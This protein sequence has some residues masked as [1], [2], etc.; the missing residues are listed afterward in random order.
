MVVGRQEHIYLTKK[1]NGVADV[2]HFVDELFWEQIVT[3]CR[4]FG[5]LMML[6]LN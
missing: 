6:T 2:F 5:S 3:G 1:K 4:A